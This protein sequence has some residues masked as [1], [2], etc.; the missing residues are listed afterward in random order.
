MSKLCQY[1]DGKGECLADTHMFKRNRNGE[2][3]CPMDKQCNKDCEVI[4]H[5]KPKMV[6]VKGIIRQ[7]RINCANEKEANKYQLTQDNVPCTI[8]IEAKYLKESK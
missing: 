2:W 4:I 7:G 3:K 1:N 5:S 8:L 6:R